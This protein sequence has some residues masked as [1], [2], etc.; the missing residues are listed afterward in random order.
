[1]MMMM[2]MMMHICRKQGNQK[3]REDEGEQASHRKNC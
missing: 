2:M 1:M 3:N